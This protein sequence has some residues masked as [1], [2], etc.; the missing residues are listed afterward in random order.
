METWRELFL[1]LLFVLFWHIPF[2]LMVYLRIRKRQE[3]QRKEQAVAQWQSL[4]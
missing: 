2:L 3:N 1:V 4:D